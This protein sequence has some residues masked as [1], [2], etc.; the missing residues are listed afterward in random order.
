MAVTRHHFLTP[1]GD[2]QEKFHE[3]KYLL[4]VPL[5]D[6][7]DIVQTLPSSWMTLCVQKGLCD[8]QMDAFSSLHSALAHGFS[9]DSVRTLAKLLVEHTFL[10]D[11][12]AFGESACKLQVEITDQVLGGPSSDLGNM[13]QSQ[14]CFAATEYM[15]P[16]TAVLHCSPSKKSIRLDQYGPNA[17]K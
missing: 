7:N 3:Q 8:R 9:I 11:I 13:I 15:Q 6:S 16:F 17:V 5:N 4:A 10:A 14:T 12:P 2:K 1:A